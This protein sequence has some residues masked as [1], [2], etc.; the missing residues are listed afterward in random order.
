MNQFQLC[1]L[2]FIY[3]SINP[4][5]YSF[6]INDARPWLTASCAKIGISSNRPSCII[7]ITFWKCA[8]SSEDIRVFSA[9]LRI[10][11]AT[12]NA[13]ANASNQ[14]E[15]FSSILFEIFWPNKNVNNCEPC[16]VYS[17]WRNF[18]IFSL[19]GRL[20]AM[21]VSSFSSRFPGQSPGLPSQINWREMHRSLCGHWNGSDGS[22]HPLNWWVGCKT[23]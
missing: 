1:S 7:C 15:L 17:A 9:K 23:S 20:A 21:H 14:N 19:A 13:D 8:R 22:I 4:D 16:N 10:V 6:S 2:F 5:S 12:E 18:S 3:W 11:F